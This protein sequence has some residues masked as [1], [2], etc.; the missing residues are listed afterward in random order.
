MLLV[1]FQLLPLFSVN[2][3]VSWVLLAGLVDPLLT[4]YHTLWLLYLAGTRPHPDSGYQW[5]PPW[6]TF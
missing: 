2:K 3:A 5:L 6:G 4:K 1:L